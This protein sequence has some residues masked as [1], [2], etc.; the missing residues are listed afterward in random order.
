MDLFWNMQ[1]EFLSIMLEKWVLRLYII[2]SKLNKQVDSSLSKNQVLISQ[3][4]VI[5]CYHYN[6]DY[7]TINIQWHQKEVTWTGIHQ[8]EMRNNAKKLFFEL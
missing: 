7:I 8:Q 1:W 5:V 6:Y 3:T 4:T 2:K